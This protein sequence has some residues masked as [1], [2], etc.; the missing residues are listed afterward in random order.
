MLTA[1]L[2]ARP[3]LAHSRQK[4]RDRLLR[5]G[6]RHGHHQ[7]E[8]WGIL[9]P[10]K[11]MRRSSFPGKIDGETPMQKSR[12]SEAQRMGVLRQVSR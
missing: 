7:R 10:V 5:G 3:Q 6:E 1:V 2:A 8:E 4:V 11:G 12:F 9:P